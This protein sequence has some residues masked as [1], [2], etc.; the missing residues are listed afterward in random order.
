MRTQV[1]L[2]TVIAAAAA[3]A[4]GSKP[5]AEKPASAVQAAPAPVR[6]TC[7]EI[8]VIMR[9]VV[10]AGDE[11]AGPD[12]VKA[13]EM[14]C[15]RDG[16]PQPAIDCAA[17]TTQPADCLHMLNDA[18]RTAYERR[19]R[20]WAARY[21]VSTNPDT[22]APPAPAVPCADALHAPDLI[23]PP[24]DDAH[25]EHAWAAA[26]RLRVLTASCE[27][28]PW[29]E[30]VKTCLRDATT[31]ASTQACALDARVHQQLLDIQPLATAIATL[32]KKPKQLDCKQVVAHHYGDARWA[33]KLADQTPAQRKKTIAD[34]RA[35]M[36]QVCS[37][38]PWDEAMRACVIADGGDTCF[39]NTLHWGYPAGVAASG[40]TVPDCDAYAAAVMKL[41][42]CT[43]MPAP[44]RD[45]LRQGY[46]SAAAS[47]STQSVDA[48][49]TMCVTG[50]EAVEQA[51][52]ANSC[53]I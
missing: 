3:A 4:C 42:L 23:D 10:D 7:A 11:S 37:M 13:I 28:D 52:T 33:G 8:A 22:A 48:Q 44:A 17:S 53:P 25:P 46:D 1:G 39:G 18:Q 35:M 43:R 30:D 36:L 2:I 21:G 19:M 20:E 14:S 16:W 24:L 32:R 49:A 12:R 31:A 15:V 50:K 45:V 47:W 9:G 27:L 41:M 5:R 40:T 29:T 6:P 26:Q 38:A 51:A 34:S